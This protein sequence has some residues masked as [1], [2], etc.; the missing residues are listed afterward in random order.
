[1]AM[2]MAMAGFVI[3][4]SRVRHPK[5]EMFFSDAKKGL[6]TLLAAMKTLVT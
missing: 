6:A 1:M 2:A 3:G 4:Q 5:T